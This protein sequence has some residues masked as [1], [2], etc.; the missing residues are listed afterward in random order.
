MDIRNAHNETPFEIATRFE[1]VEMLDRLNEQQ[2]PSMSTDDSPISP[3]ETSNTLQDTP[4]TTPSTSTSTEEQLSTGFHAL[5]LQS[6][7]IDL[8]SNQSKSTTG[9][10]QS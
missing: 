3:M 5:A 4:S 2:R 1:L 8:F 7:S 9:E 6:P 10:L